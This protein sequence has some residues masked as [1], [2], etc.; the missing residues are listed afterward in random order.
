[1]DYATGI[2]GPDWKAG[3]NRSGSHIVEMIMR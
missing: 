3:S 2:G 1:M